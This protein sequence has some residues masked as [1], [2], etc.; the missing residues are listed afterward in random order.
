VENMTDKKNFYRVLNEDLKALIEDET[1][2][3]ANCAN[4][5]ALLFNRMT[6]IN[7]AGFY[8]LKEGVLVLGPFQ[9]KPA[10][11]RIP[12]G[13]GVCGTA[14]LKRETQV[15]EDVHRFEGH[16]ACDE[17]SRSEIVVPIIR[18]NR[19]IGVLDIDSPVLKRF[20][21]ADAEGL[22]DTVALLNRYNRWS[23]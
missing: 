11:V 3:V 6:D 16:I 1:D 4:C 15:V 12:M 20:D 18:N 13:K 22:S 14:A 23:D 19:V 10:C 7:W 8:I 5:S 2:W 17:A 21:Q 9:G